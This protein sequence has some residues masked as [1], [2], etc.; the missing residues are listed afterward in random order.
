VASLLF[1][2]L[3]VVLGML[4]MGFQMLANRLLSPHYGSSIIEWVWLISTFLAAFSSG[5]M[6]GGWVSHLPAARRGRWQL[7]VALAAVASLAVTAFWQKPML[8]WIELRFVPVAEMDHHGGASMNT[9]V[10]LSC[11][12]LFFVPVTALSSFGPQCVGWLAARGTPPGQASGLVYGI[13]TVGN[14]AGVML[15]V[16]KLIPNFRV[17]HLLYGWL[18]VAAVSLAALLLLMRCTAPKKSSP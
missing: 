18:G 1:Y 14:I 12:A 13:S 10:F 11:R 9:A 17:S 8:D 16:F 4:S 3:V 7:A 5:S 15:T 2:L 6:L